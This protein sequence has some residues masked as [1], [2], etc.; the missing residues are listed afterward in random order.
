[1]KSIVIWPNTAL[2]ISFLLVTTALL[3][4]IKAET[5]PVTKGNSWVFSYVKYVNDVIGPPGF[6]TA[7][8]LDTLKTG[9][10]S[11]SID[12]VLNRNDSIFFS[13]SCK[14]SGLSTCFDTTNYDQTILD[15]SKASY[16]YNRSW[17]AKYSIYR[18]SII[19][20][21]TFSSAAIINVNSLLSYRR[22][23]DSSRLTLPLYQRTSDSIKVTYSDSSYVLFRSMVRQLDGSAHGFTEDTTDTLFW[24]QGIGMLQKVFA[25]S[26]IWEPYWSYSDFEKTTLV[27]FNGKLLSTLSSVNRLSTAKNIYQTKNRAYQKTI[28]LGSEP[29]PFSGTG[30]YTNLLGQKIGH[31]QR[32]VII[33]YK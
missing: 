4:T 22:L 21:D 17:T 27:S 30:A 25:G 10:L 6:D 24:I 28:W 2:F 11:L 32:A 15:S 14:D 19:S 26:N 33:R 16:T 23:P 8:T 31:L 12:S 9:M 7:Y 29:T 18:D 20:K 3:F 5:I 1:M 13:M